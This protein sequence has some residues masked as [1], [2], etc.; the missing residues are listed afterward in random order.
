MKKYLVSRIFGVFVFLCSVM[1]V[2]SLSPL[3]NVCYA[4]GDKIDASKLKDY[5]LESDDA[6]TKNRFINGYGVIQDR[7]GYSGSTKF[8]LIDKNYNVVLEPDTYFQ[9]EF[10]PMDKNIIY[11]YID[12]YSKFGD[13]YKITNKGLI[14]INKEMYGIS[15][16]FIY[17]YNADTTTGEDSYFNTFNMVSVRNKNSEYGVI[18][19]NGDV[20]MEF[21]KDYYYSVH[22]SLIVRNEISDNNE[23]SVPI[24]K[25]AE[26]IDEKGNVLTNTK[27]D[28]INIFLD[29]SSSKPEVIGIV[30]TKGKNINLLSLNEYKEV[31]DWSYKSFMSYKSYIIAQNS[32]GKWGLLNKGFQ[33]VIRFDYEDIDLTTGTLYGY[34]NGIKELIKFPEDKPKVSLNTKITA[35]LPTFDIT[36][37]GVK[38]ENNARLYPFIVHNDITYFPM[39]YYDSRFLNLKTEW[40]SKTGLKVLKGDESSGYIADTTKIKHPSTMNPTLA[41]FDIHINGKE[42]NNQNEPYPLL[43]YKDI[44][45]FPMT[46]RFGVDEFGWEYKFTNEKGLVINSH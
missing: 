43:L 21:S 42:I 14:K 10:D 41:V 33:V 23:L 36:L 6:D 17:S 8:G 24:L 7:S 9:I 39:T 30:V 35:N 26:I 2:L 3:F 15:H 25:N 18:N 19:R 34:K 29:Y 12:P 27:Y 32:E 16:S 45:Y 13:I 22:G 46:W 5:Y 37:N 20:V 4:V 40:N 1:I 11:G 31:L 44:T 28:K 38:I